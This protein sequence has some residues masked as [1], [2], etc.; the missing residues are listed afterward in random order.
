MSLKTSLLLLFFIMMASVAGHGEGTKQ[1]MPDS[2]QSEAGLYFE[3]YPGSIYTK[4]GIA[5]CLPNYRLHIHVKNPGESILFGMKS[6][7]PYTFTLRKPDGTIALSGTCPTMAGQQGYIRY[8]KQAVNGP[9]PLSGGYQP[10][11]YTVTSAADTGDYYFEMPNITFSSV[12]DYWD[13]QVVSGQHTPAVPADT[14]NGRVWS[15]SWQLYAL[16]ASSRS[17]NG[18]FFIYSDDGIVTRLAFNGSRVGAVTIF[19]NPY[20]CANTGNFETDRQSVNANT[21][22]SFPGIAQYKVFLNNPDPAIYPDGVYGEITSVPYMTDDP[23]FLPCSGHKLIIVEVNK[24]GKVEVVISLPYG[25]PATTVNFFANVTPG[26]NAIPWD[27]LDG[28]GNPVPDG[29][30]VNATVTFV[31]GLTNLPIW[32]QEQNR[33]GFLISLVR[34]VNPSVLTPLMYWDDTQ[35]T[36]LSGYCPVAPQESNLTGCSPGSIPGYAGCHPWGL[37]ASDCHDKMINTWWYGSTS[38]AAFADVFTAAPAAPAGHGSTRCGPGV[39]MLTATVPAGYTVDWYDTITGGVA[40]VTGDTTFFT[41]VLQTTTTYYAASRNPS[42]GCEGAV[43][44]PVQASVIPA[45]VPGLT[46]PAAACRGSAG[47]FYI[48][49]A[50][51][52]NYQWTISAGGLITGGA[53]TNAVSVTWI[54][55]GWQSVGV[56]YTD[57]N[58]CDGVSPTLIRVGVAPPPGNPGPIS[59]ADSVCSG[60]TGIVYSVDSLPGAASYTWTIPPG[61][62]ITAGSGTRAITVG[63]PAGAASGFFTVYGTNECGDGPVSPPFPVTLSNTPEASAGPDGA[64]CQGAPFLITQAT[65]SGHSH[66]RWTSSGSGTFSDPGALNPEYLPGSGETG[67]VLLVLTAFGITPC[68]NDTSALILNI[69]AAPSADAGPALPSCGVVPVSIAEATAAGFTSLHWSTT[70]T[71]TFSDPQALNP[72]Y[73]PSAEDLD[74]EQILLILSASGTGLCPAATDTAM[75]H[76]FRL[77]IADAGPD[78]ITCGTDPFPLLSSAAQHYSA[79]HWITS[80]SGTFSDPQVLHPVYTPGQEDLITGK[81]MLILTAGGAGTCPAAID[82][83]VLVVSPPPLVQTAPDGSTCAG[84][85][86]TISGSGAAHYSQLAWTHNGQGTLSGEHT[87]EPVYTP[88]AGETGPVTFTLTATGTGFCADDTVSAKT[89]IN[90]HGQVEVDAGP[91]QTIPF[92][93]A[94]T[95]SGSAEGG[96]GAYSYHWEPASL[97]ISSDIPDPETLPLKQPVTFLLTVT[98]LQTGCSG[99]DTVVVLIGAQHQTEECLVIHNVITPNGDGVNDTWIIDCMEN[100]PLNKVEIFNRWGTRVNEIEHYDNVTAVWRGTNQHGDILPDGTY[101]YV[102]AISNGGTHTGWVFIRGG[103]K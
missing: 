27:G 75:L 101:Y 97:L 84:I 2:T 20:G 90:I 68:G 49:D 19:C 11:S 24:A 63:F 95:L 18:R 50:G 45:P 48:T 66:L 13:F 33:N 28:Q 32:D 100:F 1:L 30:P 88:P 89:K 102:I 83:V 14:I 35:L 40:L 43:R 37:N 77:P 80:G 51:K 71:G 72:A 60:A 7:G 61:S 94:T 29:T 67:P 91:G 15:Q 81:V 78:G 65:A 76:L 8:Y 42:S 47:N 17:F 86:F 56:N 58:G 79:L 64:I 85:P 12:V 5:G 92:G 38:V 53:G 70:G 39:V 73:T 26:V 25:A 34:P 10:L 96:S 31:N 4:F 103:G 22:I 21:F 3:N 93:A 52:V 69:L 16:L 98:D 59:G 44:V 36:A 87:L 62:V 55:A 54:T 57:T 99:T 23:G 41:P 46:G 6:D 9:F 74:A 82:T